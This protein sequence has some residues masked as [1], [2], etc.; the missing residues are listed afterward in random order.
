MSVIAWLLLALTIVCLNVV[1]LA[2]GK[3]AARGEHRV[4]GRTTPEI[5]ALGSMPRP[6]TVADP[7]RR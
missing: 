4:I 3:M 7:A 1:A 2:L 6:G 5:S